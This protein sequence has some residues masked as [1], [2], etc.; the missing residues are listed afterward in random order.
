VN[1]EED[2]TGLLLMRFENNE[3]YNEGSAVI[4]GVF[5]DIIQIEDYELLLIGSHTVAWI[6]VYAATEFW[7]RLEESD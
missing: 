5:D 3:W 2:Q 6:S 1:D 4:S 7:F